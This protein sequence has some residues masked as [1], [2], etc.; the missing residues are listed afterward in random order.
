MPPE[1]QASYAVSSNG[2]PMGVMTREFARAGDGHYVFRSHIQATR[3]LYALL[4]V[5]VV[6]ESAWRMQ[7]DVFQPLEYL[8]RQTGA[9]GREVAVSFDWERGLIRNRAKGRTWEMESVPGVLDKLLY[10]LVLM[11]DLIAGQDRFD[12]VVADGGKIKKYH[13][14]Q[15]G[16]ETVETPLGP[17]R[18]VRLEHRK[19]G[20]K[21]MTTL[22]CARELQFLPVRLDHTEKDGLQTSAIIQSVSGLTAGH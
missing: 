17:L 13:I 1:F 19:A 16:E 21:R 9:A 12:Y 7:A 8:Y 4:R 10:Q 5:K 6:E 3:G 15:T 20:S 14:E 2:S 22:W 18:T 11:R